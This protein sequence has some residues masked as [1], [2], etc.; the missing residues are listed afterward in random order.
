MLDS[1]DERDSA[2]RLSYSLV[3][4]GFTLGLDE[5]A[6]RKATKLGVAG[7]APYGGSKGADNVAD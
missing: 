2:S 1:Q 4:T 7:A 6:I 5:L 3:F